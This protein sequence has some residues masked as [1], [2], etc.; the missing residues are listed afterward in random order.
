[1]VYGSNYPDGFNREQAILAGIEERTPGFE[2]YFEYVMDEI[3]NWDELS[4]DEQDRIRDEKKDR[5]EQNLA[6]ARAE[7]AAEQAEWDATHWDGYEP[8]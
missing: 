3:E 4:E 2:R 5:Y 8:W 6:D 1:M 7:D